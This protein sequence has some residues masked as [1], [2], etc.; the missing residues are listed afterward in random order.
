MI[1]FNVKEYPFLMAV[2]GSFF[3]ARAYWPWSY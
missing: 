1:G 3:T 2:R